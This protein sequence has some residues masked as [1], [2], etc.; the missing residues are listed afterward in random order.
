MKKNAIAM[1]LFL[2]ALCISPPAR[3]FENDPAQFPVKASNGGF[4]DLEFTLIDLLYPYDNLLKP[5]N[6][7]A[8]LRLGSI[9]RIKYTDD[10]EDLNRSGR[11]GP[12]GLLPAVPTAGINLSL[13]LGSDL[14]EARFSGSGLNRS[15]NDS[16]EMAGEISWT[17]LPSISLTGG[18]KT[19]VKDFNGE[20]RKLD[21]K[22]PGP[23][24]ELELSF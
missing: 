6:V 5:E 4:S 18:Y 19:F 22:A 7:R 21:L 13:G 11:L 9:V 15:M 23:Y 16:Y 24:V 14:V 8:R 12:E 2:F 3:A 1:I 20:G 10:S 17:P